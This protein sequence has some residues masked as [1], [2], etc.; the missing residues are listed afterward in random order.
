M[1]KSYQKRL[2]R[3]AVTGYFEFKDFSDSK[4]HLIEWSVARSRAQ[5]SLGRHVD[6]LAL[7]RTPARNELQIFVVAGYMFSSFKLLPT[8]PPESSDT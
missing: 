7:G 1:Q 2:F 5:F 4:I 3:T 8:I 6:Q